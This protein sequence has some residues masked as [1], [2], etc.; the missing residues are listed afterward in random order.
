M[1]I[2]TGMWIVVADGARGLVLVNEGSAMEPA[3]KVVRVY[4][5][6]NPRTSEQGRDKPPRAFS[7][8]GE[9]RSA[10]AEI[11]LHRRAEDRF[12]DQIVADVAK[13][14]EAGRFDAL[15]VVAP[16][17]ALGE[18]RKAADGALAKKIVATLDKDLTNHTIPEI[19]ASVAKA[20]EG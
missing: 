4:E 10:I 6:D 19:T 7:S 13:D 12:V 1:K 9:H 18:M 2:K 11:D 17:V 3:L 5:Q 20:L 15:V 14:S 16:P 8:V